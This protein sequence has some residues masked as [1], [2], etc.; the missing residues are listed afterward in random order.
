VSE[1]VVKANG[2]DI[3][4]EAFGDPSDQTILLVMG[5]TASMLQWHEELCQRLADGGRYVIRYSRT[6][7]TTRSACSTRTASIAPTSSARRWGG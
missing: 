6:W 5:A 4:T 1:K 3:C 2:V 7:P